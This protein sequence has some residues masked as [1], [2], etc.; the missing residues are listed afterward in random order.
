MGGIKTWSG[1]ANSEERIRRLKGKLELAD[2]F[3]EVV[4]MD[5]SQRREKNGN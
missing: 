5:Q 1:I 3:S 4:S 2:A